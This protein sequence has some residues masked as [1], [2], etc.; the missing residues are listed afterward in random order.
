M[1][2]MHVEKERTALLQFVLLVVML[3]LATITYLSFM[4]DQGYMIPSLTVFCLCACLYA[5]DKES[6]LK[7]LHQQLIDELVAKELEVADEK[8]RAEAL[9]I[10][11]K[12][13]TGLYRAISMVNSGTGRERTFDTV[14]RA[15]L[16]LVDGNCGSVMLMDEGR[17]NLITVT[18]HG[19][20]GHVAAQDPRKIGE[21]IAGWAAKNGEPV[22][23]QGDINEND[24]FRDV[25][26]PQLDVDLSMSVPLNLRDKVMGVINLGI[27]SEGSKNEFSEYDLRMTTIF[28]QHASVAI[29]NARLM[30]SIAASRGTVSA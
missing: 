23:L 1:R 18:S 12:E 15:A 17:A 22:L 16:D 24:R 13:L 6:R 11:L 28:A 3:F 10:R 26:S 29:E 2:L 19:F 8:G 14:L 4:Q 7:K 25:F 20:G 9:A 5:I 30:K 21:G 27:T